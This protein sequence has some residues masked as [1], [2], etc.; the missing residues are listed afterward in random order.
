MSNYFVE[1]VECH[2][3]GLWRSCPQSEYDG[4]CLSVCDVELGQNEIRRFL[5]PDGSKRSLPR[6]RYNFGYSRD[7]WERI[8]LEL[9][10]LEED[11]IL[12]M[13]FQM[14]SEDLEIDSPIMATKLTY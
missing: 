3:K 2:C 7:E 10:E 14:M 6:P 9:I 5:K 11:E 13:R 4:Y 12:R 8:V 1:P